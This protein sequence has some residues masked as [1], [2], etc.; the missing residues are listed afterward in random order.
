MQQPPPR[1]VRRPTT[2]M[3]PFK[4]RPLHRTEDTT[5]NHHHQ[6]RYTEEKEDEDFNKSEQL[7]LEYND[8]YFEA[9]EEAWERRRVEKR[10]EDRFDEEHMMEGD[11]VNVK[12]EEELSEGEVGDEHGE[13]LDNFKKERHDVVRERQKRKEL[14]VFVGGLDRDTNEDDLKEVF[15]QVGE[16]T[17]VRLLMNPLTQKNKGFAFIRFATVDQSRRAL[18]ELKRP[19]ING[20]QCGVAPSQDS[21]TLFVG[22]ICK[23]WTKEMLK[24]KLVRYGVDKFEELTLVE[25]SKNEG[26][27]RG[28]AF[29]DFP[30]R[31]DA[32]EACRRL[33]KRDVVF[34]TDRSARVAFADTFIEPD[35]EIMAQVKTVFVDGLPSSWDEEV[36]REHLREFG[37]IEKVELARNMPAAKRSDFGFVTFNSHDAAVSCVDA[38]HDSELVYG[39][40]KVKVRARLSRP[41]QRGKSAKNARGGYPVRLDDYGGGKGSWGSGMSRM[42][43]MDRDRRSIR[44]RSPYDGSHK[45]SFDSRD[46]RLYGDLDADRTGTRRQFLPADRSFTRRS[47]VPVYARSSLKTDYALEDDSFSRPRDFTGAPTERQSYRDAY[48]SRGSGYLDDSPRRVSRIAAR[49]SSPPYEDDGGRYGYME[50]SSSYHDSSSRDYSSIPSLKRPYS[51]IDEPHSR[52]AESSSRQPRA[53][54]AYGSSS[55]MLY[56]ERFYGNDSTRPVRGARSAYNGSGRS[57][58]A[59]SHGPYDRGTSRMGYR[60]GEIDSED[61]DEIYSKYSREHE[62]RDYISSRSELR[63]GSYSPVYSGHRKS[64]GYMGS[65]VSGSYY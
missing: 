41:R 44:S 60:R 23:S 46:K 57:S 49:K 7:E 42:D 65:R 25:D 38:V 35:D 12:D 1:E 58:A 6:Q 36:I 64:D 62:S 13:E 39:N 20:K 34:G 22:N 31:A 50:H 14:E 47:P 43:P 24:E 45:R 30:S 48:M 18:I 26:M 28:F 51:A 4:K 33:Q 59:H 55:D 8:P 56:N 61:A 15:S 10:C 40:K 27:N 32:L 21:D 63:A 37:R 54:L 52:Y 9:E 5:R 17:E 53:R 3:T 2:A 16:V 19:V 29:L 11:K